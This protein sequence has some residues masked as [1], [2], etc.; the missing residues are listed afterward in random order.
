MTLRNSLFIGKTYCFRIFICLGV[1]CKNLASLAF[2]Y[3]TDITFTDTT[4]G[5]E[6][7]SVVEIRSNIDDPPRQVTFYSFILMEITQCLF[8]ITFS[9]NFVHQS[10]ILTMMVE[11]HFS[12]RCVCECVQ[13]ETFITSVAELWALLVIPIW[14]V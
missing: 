5:E 4:S 10:H 11:E 12:I 6:L 3:D 9:V 14:C 7:A 2:A 1:R 13:D 8:S